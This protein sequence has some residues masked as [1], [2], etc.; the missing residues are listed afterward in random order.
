M[1]ANPHCLSL[2]QAA[3]RF[4][5]LILAPILFR[6]VASWLPSMTSIPDSASGDL[7]I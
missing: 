6:F 1:F 2:L 7:L 5:S 3:Y 4:K